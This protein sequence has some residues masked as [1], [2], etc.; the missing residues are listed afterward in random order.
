[1]AALE[2]ALA[3]A[4]GACALLYG[5]RWLLALGAFFG[6]L[7]AGRMSLRWLQ[8]MKERGWWPWP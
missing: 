4:L 6:A 7:L 1:M 2:Q 5:L 8:G 3:L